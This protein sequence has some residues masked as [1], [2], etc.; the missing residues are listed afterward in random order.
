MNTPLRRGQK[1][2][3]LV[4]WRVVLSFLDGRSWKPFA[5]IMLFRGVQG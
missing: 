5:S 3:P 4:Q 1:Y 2:L